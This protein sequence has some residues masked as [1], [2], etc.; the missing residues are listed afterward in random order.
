MI[1]NLN[2]V[3]AKYIDADN[4][5]NEEEFMACFAQDAVVIDEQRTHAG[6]EEIRLWYRQTRDE[7][8][9]TSEPI[10][11]TEADD[12]MLLT[13]T[14]SGNFPGSPVDLS[15]RFQLNSGKIARLRID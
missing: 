5:R 10:R 7:Y 12:E 15:Y 8:D 2:P 1:D 3:I 9:F 6:P 4:S 14:V 11:F 13:C